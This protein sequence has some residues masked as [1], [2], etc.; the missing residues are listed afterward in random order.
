MRGNESSEMIRYLAVKRLLREARRSQLDL[1][2]DLNREH[3]QRTGGDSA[4]EGMIEA[5]ELASRMQTEVP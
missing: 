5:N 2:A 3:L 1:L 4:L